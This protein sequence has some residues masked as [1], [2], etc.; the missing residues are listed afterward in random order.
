MIRPA[1]RAGDIGG[2]VELIADLDIR[3]AAR[4]GNC[5]MFSL[6][7][8]DHRERRGIRALGDGDVNR[9]PSVDQRV[10]G[11]DVGAVFDRADIAHED[12]LACPA[13]GWECCPGP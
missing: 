10:T 5:G 9:A 7:R 12:G 4:T 6:T 3:P 13:S 1:N 2:L 11:L 8:S